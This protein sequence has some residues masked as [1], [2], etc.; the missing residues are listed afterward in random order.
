MAHRILRFWTGV[1]RNEDVIVHCD[2]PGQV[3]GETGVIARI[4]FLFF[5]ND[6]AGM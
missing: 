5:E 1:D 2:P 4:P 6:E 3:Y